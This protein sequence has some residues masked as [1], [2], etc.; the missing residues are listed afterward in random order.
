MKLLL[1]IIPTQPT[2]SNPTKTVKSIQKLTPTVLTV[3][4]KHDGKIAV[5]TNDDEVI[6]TEDDIGNVFQDT[7]SGEKL[8]TE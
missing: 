7:S 1:Y 3:D 8:G 6:L 4:V 5:V 2:T